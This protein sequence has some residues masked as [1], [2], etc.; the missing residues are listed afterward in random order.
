MELIMN[1]LNLYEH[2]WEWLQGVECDMHFCEYLQANNIT[3]STVFH[4][5]TGAHHKLG[6]NL[7]NNNILGITA[8]KN[9]YVRYMALVEDNP[10][11]AIRYKVI[12]GDIYTLSPDIL[13]MFDYINLFHLCEYSNLNNNYGQMN[14]TQLLEMFRTRLNDNGQ[15]CFFTGSNRYLNAKVILDNFVNIGKLIEVSEYKSIKTYKNGVQPSMARLYYSE[16]LV[17]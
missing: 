15:L 5:G 1:K 13:P 6:I 12:F 8:S 14:D 2:T 3:N 7:T 17:K 16:S 4:F 9:E 11:I 10:E